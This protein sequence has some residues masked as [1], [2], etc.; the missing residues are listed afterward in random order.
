MSGFSLLKSV[1]RLSF[2]LFFSRSNP[3]CIFIEFYCNLKYNID[4]NAK[5]FM[6]F[7]V[8]VSMHLSK[9]NQQKEKSLKSRHKNH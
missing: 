9:A 2:F 3:N 4:E 7:S 5:H 8:Y 1:L 6:I